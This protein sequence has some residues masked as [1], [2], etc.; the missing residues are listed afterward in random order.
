MIDYSKINSRR[1]YNTRTIIIASE[2]AQ[3]PK[4]HNFIDAALVERRKLQAENFEGFTVTIP[5]NNSMD[6][7]KWIPKMQVTLGNHTITDNFYVVNV[8]D[9]NV[10]LGVQWLYSL[11]EHIVNYQF[12]KIRLKNT[13]GKHILLRGMHTYPNQ[14]AS[15]HIMR[16]FEAWRYRMGC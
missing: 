4:T 7:T 14:V 8:A 16:T 10:V 13:E 15:S 12:P 3:I 6:C 5:G 9:S 11:G 2:V 1:R